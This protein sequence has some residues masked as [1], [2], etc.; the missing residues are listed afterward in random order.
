ME[1]EEYLSTVSSVTVLLCIVG[2]SF[3]TSGA[4]PLCVV[5]IHIIKEHL[6]PGSAL[7]FF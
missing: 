3:S 1:E 4:Y 6:F 7:I 2:S 5:Q